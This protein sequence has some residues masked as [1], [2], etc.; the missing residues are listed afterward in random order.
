MEP[1]YGTLQFWD[2]YSVAELTRYIL[3]ENSDDFEGLGDFADPGSPRVLERMCRPHRWTLLHEFIAELFVE[4]SIRAFEHRRDDMRDL[5]ALEYRFILKGYGICPP[6]TTLPPET[7]EGYDEASA[8]IIAEL[9]ELLPIGRIASETFHVLFTNRLLLREFNL[10]V[11]RSV[12]DMKVREF[13]HALKRDGV[14]SRAQ[15]PAW[16][17]RGIFYRDQGRCAICQRDLSGVLSTDQAVAFDHV[18]ALAAGGTNDPT[19]FQL[20]CQ[21]CNLD[22]SA[23]A[24]SSNRYILFWDAEAG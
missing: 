1:E 19:N 4:S 2:A 14:L 7:S 17:R 5:V 9:R 10:L 23:Q 21:A 24:T 8:G 15:L 11:A 22:K 13:P 20:L 12:K 6:Q 3:E 16:A 18:V